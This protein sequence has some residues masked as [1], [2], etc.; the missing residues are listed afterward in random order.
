MRSNAQGE[1][2]RVRRPGKSAAI[3]G[4]AETRNVDR[5]WARQSV[6]HRFIFSRYFLK[7][8]VF[9]K[10]KISKMPNITPDLPVLAS[11]PP[12]L[13]HDEKIWLE[14]RSHWLQSSG[15]SCAAIGAIPLIV[16]ILQATTAFLNGWF[17]RNF[18]FRI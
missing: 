3:A 10:F 11:V 12:L 8:R 15:R 6:W 5:D 7:F 17:H 4:C 16:M 18:R 13:S 2:I 9:S 1:T 14:K